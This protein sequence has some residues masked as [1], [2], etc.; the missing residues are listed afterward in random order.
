MVDMVTNNATGLNCSER[1]TEPDFIGLIILKSLISGLSFFCIL[2]VIL[3]IFLFKKHQFFTQ[4]LILYLAF[5]S[6]FFSIEG[7]MNVVSSKVYDVPSLMRYCVFTG[8]LDQV[9]SWWIIMATFCIMLDIF[10]K[11][12]TFKNTE[13]LEWVYVSLIFVL[14]LVLTSW[15]PFIDGAYGPAGPFCWIR[16]K[17]LSDCSKYKLGFALQFVLYFIP[18]YVLMAVV[19]ILL[20]VSILLLRRK[21]KSWVGRYDHDA[22]QLK[23]RMQ[24]EIR[25]LF[26]YPIIII[27]TNIL[28]CINQIYDAI[29]I[30][31]TQVWLWYLSL[32]TYKLQGV[33]ITLGFT[34]DRETRSKLT[35]AQIS[36][37]LRRVFVKEGIQEYP[38]GEGDT[39]DMSV[40]F[41]QVKVHETDYESM[42]D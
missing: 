27:C 16:S 10:I 7:C 28:P 13:R 40:S 8:F 15:I 36:A 4:R 35:L 22:A 25:P 41:T 5:S 33:L 11:V 37:A 2:L 6:L 17:N 26:I 19:L 30:H 9:T 32:T 39:D 14:P 3:F 21:S 12:L 20:V 31:E 18:L 42:N 23:R 34:M 1:F 38:V 24:T 29:L